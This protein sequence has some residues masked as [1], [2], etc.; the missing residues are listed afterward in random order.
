M[1]YS[2]G[3][4]VHDA[5]AHLMETPTWLGDHADPGVRDRLEPLRYAGGNELKQ[6]G[7]P[8]EQRRDLVAAA[9]RLA[10]KHRSTE[11]TAAEEEEVMLR[12]NFA[13]K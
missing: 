12:K 10:D 3:R 9:D 7:D 5:D 13:A 4:L 11:Y 1:P 6:T 2:T 8:G